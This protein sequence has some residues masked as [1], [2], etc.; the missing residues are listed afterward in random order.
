MKAE[1]GFTLIELLVVI[2]ILG[3]LA[4]VV[5]AFAGNPD[6]T[7]RTDCDGTTLV[8]KDWDGNVTAAIPHSDKCD[9][10]PG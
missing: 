9:R 1:K 2:V 6:P 8:Y 4:A 3:I 7:Y 5:V 10:I